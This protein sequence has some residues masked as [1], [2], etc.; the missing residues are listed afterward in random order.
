[1]MDRRFTGLVFVVVFFVLGSATE[2]EA[3]DLVEDDE[4][5]LSLS[6]VG[7]GAARLNH[8]EADGATAHYDMNFA[9]LVANAEYAERGGFFIQV[10]ARTGQ[11]ALLDAR[12]SLQIAEG[13][14]AQLGRFKMPVSPEFLTSARDLLFSRR[15]ALS[16]IVAKR[17]LGGQLVAQPIDDEQ[18][19]LVLNAG[20]FTPGV[21]PGDD[22]PAGL[23]VG[24]ARLDFSER[25]FLHAAFAE[26]IIA[27]DVDPETDLRAF[28]FNRQLDLAFGLA[29]D[30]W[31]ALVE[32]LYVFDGPYPTDVMGLHV[33]AARKFS[34]EDVD[35]EPALAYDL[36]RLDHNDL[37]RA[38]AAFNTYWLGTNLMS[39]IEY[40]LESTDGRVRHLG[41]VSLQA[42]F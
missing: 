34:R 3:Y 5:T 35:L 12:A 23:A 4:L 22:P 28:P 30:T 18:V 42:G 16:G 29:D 19:G 36:L 17:S 11:V 15:A 6:G 27:N 1:M 39:T 41:T 38:T 40:A 14:D 10:G 21:M 8:D 26:N 24:R 9:R 20:V 25:Y 37:H 2:V 31:R 7:E 33:N 13:L 32:G